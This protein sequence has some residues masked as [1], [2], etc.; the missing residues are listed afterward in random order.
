MSQKLLAI[1]EATAD[2]IGI[3]E[4][5]GGQYL[6]ELI[7]PGICGAMPGLGIAD[8]LQ[9]VWQLA[10][11]GSDDRA[12]QMFEFL[13]PQ[14]VFSL[15]NMELFLWMEKDLLARRG[16]LSA[17]TCHVRAATLTPDEATWRHAQRLNERLT[18]IA[19]G[20]RD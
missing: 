15:Q 8:L 17:A 20:Y 3:F 4:G 19:D 6:M 2:R 10:K 16:V 1:R 11:T 13:L 18:F 5:W 9:Q 12:M 14:I 7:E